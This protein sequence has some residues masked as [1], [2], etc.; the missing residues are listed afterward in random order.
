MDGTETHPPAVVCDAGPV[1]HLD[2]LDCLD[3]LVDFPRVLVSTTVRKEICHHR[4]AAFARQD[5]IWERIEHPPKPTLQLEA[6][7]RLLP[8]H[9]GEVEALC[10]ALANP[11]AILL[12]DDTAARLAATSL[13]IPA[14]GTLGVLVRAIRRRQR[15]QSE[16]VEL[17]RQIPQRST[18][19]VRSS[20]LVKIIED[21]AK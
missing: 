9:R 4:P 1:I 18:L 7:A 14:H 17:L 5:I 10:V 3:L 16:V 19:Y 6:M 11:S 15:T 20:L 2:E 13:Q 21:V 8:L 12:T